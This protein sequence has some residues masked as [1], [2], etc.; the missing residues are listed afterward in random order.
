M[1]PSDKKAIVAFLLYAIAQFVVPIALF[2]GTLA[3]FNALLF[4][5]TV[6]PIGMGL[7]ILQWYAMTRSMGRSMHFV[8]VIAFWLGLACLA[9]LNHWLIMLAD[10]SC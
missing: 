9:L 10:N 8:T 1:L 2:R 7:I 5:G 4:F 3:I 6:A